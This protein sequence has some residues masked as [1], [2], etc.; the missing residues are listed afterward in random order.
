ME[1]LCG[2]SILLVASLID[3]KGA[4]ARFLGDRAIGGGVTRSSL[5][6]LFP[7]V[8]AGTESLATDWKMFWPRPVDS[9]ELGPKFRSFD[10]F[11][12]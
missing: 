2:D 11:L 10:M 8:S 6:E 5:Q 1:E 7:V 4:A 9:E 3:S 12:A